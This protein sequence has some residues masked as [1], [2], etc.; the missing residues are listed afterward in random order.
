MKVLIVDDEQHVREAIR[1]LADWKELGISEIYEADNGLHASELIEQV[2]PEILITDMRMPIQDGVKLLQHAQEQCPSMQKIVV[3]GHNDF[4]LVRSTMKYGG[5]DY[6]LKPIDPVQ[7]TEALRKAIQN[8]HK[9]DLERRVNQKRSMEINQIKPVYWDK[10]MSGL[11]ADPPEVPSRIRSMLAEEFGEGVT[12]ECRVALL[13][14]A[15]AGGAILR[16]FRDNRELLFFSLTNICNEF[17][18]RGNRG[19]ACRYW[20]SDHEILLIVWS[21][22]EEL[23]GLL[24]EINSG[25][26]Q[27]LG[28]RLD[29]GVG[30]AQPFPA[31]AA[32]SW[33]QAKRALEERNMREKNHW[34][35]IGE[36]RHQPAKELHISDYEE[37]FR[38]ALLS[39]SREE[40][41]SAVDDWLAAVGGL[42]IVTW[43]QVEEWREEWRSLIRRLGRRMDDSVD[44][45][46]EALAVPTRPAPLDPDG[47]LS[48]PEWGKE[49]RESLEQLVREHNR[50]HREKGSM[51]E[52]ARYLQDHYSREL[53]L[54]DIANHFYLSRE[55]ISR[56]FKQEFGENLSDYLGRIRIGKAKLLLQ[57]PH[58]RIAQIAEMVGYPDE[59]YFSKVFK[60]LEGKS[61]GEYRKSCGEGL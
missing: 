54:Q 40:I 24:H 46:G 2:H 20:N 34:I 4:E 15:S 23:P 8:W 26:L 56:R 52:I 44:E 18:R 27:T 6:L 9:V 36:E 10:V 13:S 1:L 16:R 22:T 35:H 19:I 5:Q 58:L 33:K 30:S 37:S 25:I 21:R 12:A 61:P 53:T 42:A 43:K 17:L 38:L 14:L 7:L 51:R 59:K 3:S 57:N 31:G 49:L 29:I 45:E 32:E 55:Y 39:G 48:F 41:A 28:S 50:A 60:K 47:C 11:V